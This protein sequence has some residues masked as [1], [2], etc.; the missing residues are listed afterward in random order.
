MKTQLIGCI[1]STR[2]LIIGEFNIN[3]LDR[4]AIIDTGATG[5]FIAGNSEIVKQS[6]LLDLSSEVC[7]K[8]ADARILSTAQ[9]IEAVVTPNSFNNYKTKLNMFIIPQRDDIMGYEVI[10]GMDAIRSLEITIEPINGLMSAH[11]NKD[12]I[13]RELRLLGVTTIADKPQQCSPNDIN[14]TRNNKFDKLVE[15]FSDIFAESAKT[16]IDTTPMRL[17][18]SADFSI[19][20]RPRPHSKDDILEIDRQVNKLLENDIVEDSESTFSANVHLVPKKNG[21]KRM[22]I[23]Y[24]FLND[25]SVKDHYPLPQINN[26]FRALRDAIYF[27]TLDCTEGFLQIAVDPVDRYKTAFVTDHGSYQ[28]K[29]CPFGY[30]NSPAKFQR[31]MN[32]IFKEG[33]YRRCVI[34]IDDILVFGKTEDELLQNLKWVFERCRAKTVKLKRTKCA[35]NETQVNFLGFNISHNKIAPVQGKYDPIGLDPPTSKSDIRAILGSFNHYAR[36]IENYADKTAP[37]RRLTRDNVKFEWSK[38]LT[39]LVNQLKN[40]L[41]KATYETIADATSPKTVTIFIS[42]ISLEVSCYDLGHKLVGRAGCVL[43]DAEKNYTTTEL[44]LLAIVHAFTKFGPF[45]KGAVTFR[46]TDKTLLPSLKLVQ[47]PERVTR[48]MLRLPPDAK[49]DVELI[50]GRTDLESAAAE[51]V[52][53][54][55]IFYTDGAC[56]RNGKSDCQASWAVLATINH[57]LSASGL[58]EYTRLSNQ[59]AEIYAI[60]KACEIAKREGFTNILIVTDSKY[61]SGAINKWISS[62]KLNDWRDVRGKTIVNH[63]LLSK[64]AKYLDILN[65]KCLHVKGHA[66]DLNNIRVDRMAKEVLERTV[67]LGVIGVDNSIVNQNEDEE[68]EQIIANLEADANLREKYEVNNGELYYVDSHLPIQCRKRLFVPKSNRKLLLRV[69]HDDPLYGG[70]LGFKKTKAKL[71]AYYWPR[72]G[73]DIENYIDSCLICQQQKASKQPKHGLLQPIKTSRVFEQIHVDIIGPIKETPRHNRNIITAIDAYSRYGFAKPVSQAKTVDIIRFLYEEVIRHHGPPVCIVSDNGPQFTSVEFSQFINKLKIKHH[74]TCEYHPQ[75]NGMDER[76]NGTI[77]KILKNYLTPSTTSDWDLKVQPAIYVYNTTRHESIRVSPYAALYG[78]NPRS[79]LRSLGQ[80]RNEAGNDQNIDSSRHSPIRK[81]IDSYAEVAQESQKRVYDSKRQPQNFRL[82]DIVKAKVHR[83]PPGESSKL[84]PKWNAP[85]VIT[86]IIRSNNNPV[87]VELVDLN[88]GQRRRSA[89][90]DVRHLNERVTEEDDELSLPGNTILDTTDPIARTGI[91]STKDLET[92][93]FESNETTTLP[94]AI[95]NDTSTSFGADQS[96]N[97]GFNPF[98]RNETF[99]SDKSLS[100][101]DI[102]IATDDKL[103]NR[104]SY[105]NDSD[106]YHNTMIGFEQP[107][108]FSSFDEIAFPNIRGVENK[109]VTFSSEIELGHDGSL[110]PDIVSSRAEAYDHSNSDIIAENNDLIEPQL[111]IPHSRVERQNTAHS[112]DINQSGQTTI[113][114][115]SAANII[116]GSANN[117]PAEVSNRVDCATKDCAGIVPG[118]DNDSTGASEQTA[119]DLNTGS[120]EASA[121]KEAQIVS[122]VRDTEV[123]ATGN[124]IVSGVQRDSTEAFVNTDRQVVSGVNI[125]STETP[126]VNI[127]QIVPGVDSDSIGACVNTL[128]ASGVETGSTGA[129]RNLKEPEATATRDTQSDPI[130]QLHPPTGESNSRRTRSHRITKPPDRYPN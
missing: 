99:D 129:F 85:C 51:D 104:V 96:I 35:F 30:T 87:A 43:K 109:T 7:I 28:Y 4:S 42:P 120:T 77:T 14:R 116:S 117:S 32:T 70:H 18:L 50:P 65:I 118:A 98:Q 95:Y 103:D 113:N 122:G 78:F 73:K 9:T 125:D 101:S 89:F 39:I 126:A 97:G 36:F 106:C 54:D 22:V 20:A 49:F 79:P 56:I 83:C 3:G 110:Q 93:A 61:A 114:T 2:S 81:S 102:S 47:R 46:T 88:T 82:F 128:I 94:R 1:G 59:I 112:A 71:L 40:D 92:N 21:T 38:E 84:L 66:T 25:I 34:Y 60:I 10:L 8:T 31:T 72:M 63:E 62:W 55:E 44:Q 53:R 12:I 29:R 6:K 68:I 24:R 105:N 41:N 130:R 57:K 127:R 74:R 16:L 123:V 75:A 11:V 90:Q 67:S 86:R 48:L 115:D 119:L 91:T 100:S 17:H 121:A 111:S 64:L 23:D 19:K 26:M 124:Q 27:A 80:D 5:S 76:L 45:L 15:E 33:L 107:S 108:F 37:I 69:S 13:A 52:S 58:V